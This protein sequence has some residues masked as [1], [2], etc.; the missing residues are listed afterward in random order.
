VEGIAWG[1]VEVTGRAAHAGPTPVEDR[2]DALVAASRIILGLRALT[3]EL[4]GVRTTAGRIEVIPNTINVV[5]GAVRVTTDMRARSPEVLNSAVRGL[6]AL[7][8][9]VAGGDGVEVRASEFWRSP[10]TP[11]HRAVTGAVAASARELGYSIRRLWAGA[12]HD[13]KYVADRYPAGMIFVPSAGGLSH[14]EAEWTP[15][16]DCARGAAVLLGAVRRLA[17][18]T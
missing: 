17:E 16:D 4:P 10:P 8:D 9:A 1:W 7:C 14:N 11:F 5:P 15:K 2:R 18:A 13:A 3:A 6:A 12:G